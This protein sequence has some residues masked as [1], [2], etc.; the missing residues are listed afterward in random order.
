MASNMLVQFWFGSWL[1]RFSEGTGF[2]K[3]NTIFSPLLIMEAGDVA[4][5]LPGLILLS[6]VCSSSYP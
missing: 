2:W 1:G 4:V 3:C 5:F 6:F